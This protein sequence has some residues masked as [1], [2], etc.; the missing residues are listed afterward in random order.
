[1]SQLKFNLNNNNCIEILNSV[2]DTTPIVIEVKISN[3]KAED[4]TLLGVPYLWGVRIYDTTVYNFSIESLYSCIECLVNAG[5]KIV[6]IFNP[7]ELFFFIKASY[8]LTNDTLRSHDGDIHK[9]GFSINGH[10]LIVRSLKSISGSNTIE[11]FCGL[12]P[13]IDRRPKCPGTLLSSQDMSMLNKFLEF[14]EKY[15][16]SLCKKYKRLSNIPN[17]LS[18][19]IKQDLALNCFAHGK[20][21]YQK[22]LGYYDKDYGVHTIPI[23]GVE[24]F[25][26]LEK[27]FQGGFV[28]Y[29]S[30]HINETIKN[31]MCF[32]FVSS[33]IAWMLA[34]RYPMSYAGKMKN[35][36]I[37]DVQSYLNRDDVGFICEVKFK[38]IRSISPCRCIKVSELI[39]EADPSLGVRSIMYENNS[40]FTDDG[41]LIS[42]DCID[43]IT[44][45]VD[46]SI[47]NKF[48]E[49]DSVEF[50]YVELYN[51]DYLPNEYISVVK[52]LFYNKSINKG[53]PDTF[54]ESVSKKKVNISYGLTVTGFWRTTYELNNNEFN[55][56]RVDLAPYID[57][58]NNFRG[59]FYNRCSAYQWGVFC[60]AYARR[61]LFSIIY[62]L[63]DDWLY[64]DTDSAYFKFKPEHIEMINRYNNMI[65]NLI[66]NSPIIK[67]ESDFIVKSKYCDKVYQLGAFSLDDEY[68]EF[69]Y[70]KSKTY[71][72]LAVD[73]HYKLVMSGCSNFNPDFFKTVK[74]FEWFDLNNE[75]S[76]V[77]L[78]Y[79]DTYNEYVQFKSVEVDVKDYRTVIHH[80]KLDG[81]CY[82]VFTDFKL[83]SSNYDN[84]KY[85]LDL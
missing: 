78:E 2:C 65:K 26:F 75:N 62:K 46:Y 74:P 24:H 70:L 19:T 18:T 73:G 3:V 66:S 40:K 84:V 61:S 56:N 28:G 43:I 47:Y 64:S 57:D 8:S 7:K 83:T 13:Y 15:L 42:S 80:I 11:S 33:Y 69:K 32:D 51:L 52:D 21:R 16:I 55:K 41:G 27:S 53:N 6:Y 38:G 77:P 85:A 10:T 25:K 58:Y 14:E 45:S 76:I 67:S 71:L 59:R 37:E 49:W 44:T 34:G 39:D 5:V 35:P 9:F 48:Y 60:T 31:V 29:N 17:T 30:S 20:K 72:G 22:L 82:R 68:S 63:G 81:G 4:G 79:C 12:P 23:N 1:M 54:I 50:L 36:S